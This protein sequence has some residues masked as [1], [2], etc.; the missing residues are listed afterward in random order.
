M[1]MTTT[2]EKTLAPRH[3]ADLARSVRDAQRRLGTAPGE[4]RSAVLRRLSELLAAREDELLAANRRDLEAARASRLAGPLM[5]RL[6]EAK[7]S[8]PGGC[9]IGARPIDLHL[10]G[11]RDLGAKVRVQVRSRQGTTVDRWRK[12]SWWTM[13]PHS[14]GDGQCDD[15]RHTGPRDN[16]HPQR[17]LRA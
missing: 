13:W 3:L 6:N 9:V 8:M 17:R 12:F 15:G 7:V 2:P 1:S 16:R 14:P 4:R 11:M 10:K 5:G